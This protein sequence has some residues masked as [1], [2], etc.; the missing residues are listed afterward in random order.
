[1]TKALKE[2][3]WKEKHKD[4]NFDFQEYLCWNRKNWKTKLNKD[5]L[6]V[7]IEERRG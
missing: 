2:E 6:E 4:G 5:C 1:V 7:F 3:L